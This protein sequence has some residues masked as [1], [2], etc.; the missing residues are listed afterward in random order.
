MIYILIFLYLVGER[1]GMPPPE[2]HRFTSCM[3]YINIG[4]G[5]LE[6]ETLSSAHPPTETLLVIHPHTVSSGLM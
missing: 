5:P 1:G 3:G 4:L 2:E 6:A